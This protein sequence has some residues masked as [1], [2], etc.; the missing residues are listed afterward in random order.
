MQYEELVEWLFANSNPILR[1]RVATDLM[2]VS[3]RERDKLFQA[4]LATPEVQYW[5]ECLRQA[6]NVHGSRDADAENAF[7]KLLEFGFNRDFTSINQKIETLLQGPLKIWDSLVLLPFLLKAGYVNHPLV[8]EWLTD[9]VEKLARTA[10]LGSFDF[11]LSPAEA[12]GV[13]KAWQGKPIYRDEYGHLAGYALP[14]CYD[15]YALA[16][17]PAIT[18]IPDFSSRSEVIAAFLSDPR[19][20]AT[21]SGYGWDHVKR[22]C[23][24][25]G[26][27]FLACAEPNR[28]V[29]F[30]EL[31]A[32]FDASRRSEWFQKGLST[33]E[34]YRT[35]RGT[36][37]FP[38]GMLPEK[39]GNFIYNGSHMGLG[40]I[41]RSQR[42]MELES[43]FRM[44][45]IHKRM[46]I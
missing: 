19:F 15:F 12:I 7:A 42:D 11:Y 24:A 32:R 8:M 6:K 29:L 20:Q 31:G 30:L 2:D 3:G 10:Q 43:T 1:Y 13:P 35:E 28:Q 37:C 4:S 38:P 45:Y 23:Y 14:T 9:R 21:A 33:L 27:V 18:N 40:G 41:R 26:R 46:Q 22:R 34:S 5:L 25:A 36:Y 39:A 17:C 44:L 16:H